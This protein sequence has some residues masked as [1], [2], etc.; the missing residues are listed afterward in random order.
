LNGRRKLGSRWI[1]LEPGRSSLPH[2]GSSLNTPAEAWRE[3][4]LPF[5]KKI[6]IDITRREGGQETRSQL[7]LAPGSEPDL[8][9]EIKNMEVDELIGMKKS[10]SPRPEADFEVYADLLK[11]PLPPDENPSFQVRAVR[12]ASISA[13]ARQRAARSISPQRLS[14]G[15][16]PMIADPVEISVDLKIDLDREEA[17]DPGDPAYRPILENLQGNILKKA[18]LHPAGRLIEEFAVVCG[19]ESHGV[20]GELAGLPVRLFPFGSVGVVQIRG[21]AAM[22]AAKHDIWS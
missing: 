12:R 20:D 17:I 15:D 7:I 3:L 13:R 1:N 6:T 22:P 21:R 9:I 11:D 2:A 10:Y 16:E 4:E 18:P 19:E 5:Q 14:R 8:R